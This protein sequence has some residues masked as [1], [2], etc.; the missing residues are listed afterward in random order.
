MGGYLVMK[1]LF[2]LFVI[3]TFS[4]LLFLIGGC[5]E[6]DDPV[7]TSDDSLILDNDLGGTK[8]PAFNVP[9]SL[10]SEVGKTFT[11]SLESNPTTGYSWTAEVDSEFLKVAD[12][13]YKS[14]SNLIGAGGVQ[15]FE[16]EALKTGQTKITVKYMRPWEN[17]AIN[18]YEITVTINPKA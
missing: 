9:K 13:T 11:V 18:K 3:V 6:K 14:D 1:K 17:E 10:T 16:F 7:S 4:G 8:S 12:D 15:T 2:C 5:S